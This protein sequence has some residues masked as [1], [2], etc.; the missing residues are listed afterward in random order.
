MRCVRRKIDAQAG[1]VDGEDRSEHALSGEYEVGRAVK[2]DGG[3]TR[4]WR[5]RAEIRCKKHIAEARDYLAHVVCSG[6]G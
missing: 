3:G 5:S 2:G 1:I 4:E 6:L